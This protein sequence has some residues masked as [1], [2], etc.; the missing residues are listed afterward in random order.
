V[1][2]V[3]SLRGKM[4]AGVRADELPEI[5]RRKSTGTGVVSLAGRMPASPPLETAPVLAATPPL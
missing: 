1:I 4:R 5:K 2:D 3:A